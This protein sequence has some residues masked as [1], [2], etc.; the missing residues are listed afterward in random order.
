MDE[1]SILIGGKAGDGINQAG[2]LIARVFGQL[3]WYAYI[4]YDYP[5]LI[6][7]G[8]NF[9]I[10]RLSKKRNSAHTNKINFLLALNQDAVDLHGNK[11]ADGAMVIY[12]SDLSK[13]EGIGVALEKIVKE[14]NAPAIM[15]NSCIIG[16]LCKAV[17]LSW[18]V[19]EKVFRQ[20]ISKE[21]D[22]NL[23]LARR[24][25]EA[26]SG[27]VKI[28][29]TGGKTLP[30]VTGNEAIGMGLYSAGLDA[31]IAYPMTPSS[32]LLHFLAEKAGSFGIK[33]I[34][35]E[36]EI[37][38]M[39][40]ALGFAYAGKKAAVGTSGGGFCLMTEGL[41]LSGMAELPVVILLGQRP[42][43]STGMPTYS[44][45]TELH[46]SLN[47]A[48]GEFVRFVVAPGDAEEAYFWAQAALNFAGKFQIPAIILSDKNLSEGS[49][50][51]DIGAIEEPKEC[52]SLLW[53]R[54]GEF[55]RYAN[56]ESGISPL[57]FV[58]DKDAVIK[59][60]SYEHDEFGITTEESSTVV[61]MQDK[62]LRKEKYLVEEL[63]D[64]PTI[65]AY[66][67][68]N[69]KTILLCWGSNKGVCLEVADNLGLKAVSVA[70]LSPFPEEKLRKALMGAEK[71][72]CVENNATGQ[73]VRLISMFGF[74]V[75]KKILKYDGRPFSVEELEEKAREAL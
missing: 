72:I 9:S 63:E 13:S 34:H 19:L 8:H 64:Y 6:R 74:R 33:V 61:L 40:M 15:R 21:I 66:G 75:D 7:G 18:E 10:I 26:V 31:Y 48:Q 70:V 60:N 24:G 62:R 67:N 3:G 17:D 71:I 37:G 43:P 38:V 4:Y 53:N 36:S 14:E 69:S 28:E 68:L 23:R 55:K 65:K 29:N 39:L 46:F 5:S 73:F 41:S 16:A 1:F 51:F 47:A 22:L 57:T 25:Y 59:V 54:R 35:P 30:L 45:Q 49:F 44:A 32:S 52:A 27:I 2:L 50:N 56:T 12:N 20:N 42:G 58:P 11:L